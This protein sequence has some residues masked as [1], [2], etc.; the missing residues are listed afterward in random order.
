MVRNYIDSA[1]GT[2]RGKRTKIRKDLVARGDPGAGSLR[3]GDMLDPDQSG[4]GPSRSTIVTSMLPIVA[5]PR[6]ALPDP[7]LQVLAVHPESVE[8]VLP[9]HL[10]E[11]VACDIFRAVVERRNLTVRIEGSPRRKRTASQIAF[12]MARSV[13]RRL[14]A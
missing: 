10:L 13:P 6:D 2:C 14:P 5:P 1:A 3:P 12:R 8:V 4:P 9:E 7:G 11:P